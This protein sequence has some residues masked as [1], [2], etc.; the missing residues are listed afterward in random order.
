MKASMLEPGQQITSNRTCFYKYA[1]ALQHTVKYWGITHHYHFKKLGNV[2]STYDKAPTFPEVRTSGQRFC[3]SELCRLQ[4]P[5]WEPS[6]HVWRA[7][8]EFWLF[9]SPT[10]GRRKWRVLPS[11]DVMRTDTF[12]SVIPFPRLRAEHSW[13]HHFSGTSEEAPV[14]RTRNKLWCLRSQQ[15]N[16]CFC[17]H[18]TTMNLAIQSS[19]VG[20]FS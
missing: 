12:V 16:C 2:Q 5:G 9:W 13:H 17:A 19:C 18:G 20:C 15:S 8:S 6:T 1:E 7:R 14:F 11:W 4:L 10:I 3:Y